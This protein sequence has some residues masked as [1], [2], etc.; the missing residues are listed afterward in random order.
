VVKSR[1]GFRLVFGNRIVR[2]E[3]I[4]LHSSLSLV[5][6]DCYCRIRQSAVPVILASANGRKILKNVFGEL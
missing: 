3:C 1:G 6:D 4:I 2:S 5:I